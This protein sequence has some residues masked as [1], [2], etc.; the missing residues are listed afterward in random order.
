MNLEEPMKDSKNLVWLDLE[1]TGLDPERDTILEIATV[2]TG[3]TFNPPLLDTSGATSTSPTTL[4]DG[5][6]TCDPAT[7]DWSPG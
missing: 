4:C 6:D 3:G 7:R 1:M 5:N 2:I